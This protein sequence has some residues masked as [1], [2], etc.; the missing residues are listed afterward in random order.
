MVNTSGKKTTAK[1]MTA[2]GRKRHVVVAGTPK[3]RTGAGRKKNYDQAAN[4]AENEMTLPE[5]ST[6]ARRGEAAAAS[7]RAMLERASGRGRPSLDP[8]AEKGAKSPARQVRLPIR[9]SARVDQLAAARG[10]T[11]AAV[12]RDAITTYV[13]E[14]PVQ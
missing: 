3:S 5:N 8:A 1:N 2:A 10:V 7:G 4:W 6:T 11:P 9:T 14:H 12:M 13:N